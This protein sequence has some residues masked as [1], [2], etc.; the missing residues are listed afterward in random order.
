MSC[1]SKIAIWSGRSK[2]D[3][4]KYTYEQVRPAKK[5]KPSKTVSAQKEEQTADKPATQAGNYQAITEQIS[6]LKKNCKSILLAAASSHALPVTIPANVAIGLANANKRCLVI[7]LDLKRNALAEAFGLDHQDE[8]NGLQP[9]AL[10]TEFENLWIW[11]ARHFTRLKQMNVGSLVRGAVDKFD[12]II[13]NAPSLSSSPDRRYIASS[14]QV[15]IIF[16]SNGSPAN[17]LAELIANS[18]CA[19]INNISTAPAN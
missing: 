7:D 17:G 5:K 14:A 3:T 4:G 10:K 2:A 11:P 12:F 1:L 15:A 13:I 19:I 9:T 8:Q 6:R 18:G 16:S